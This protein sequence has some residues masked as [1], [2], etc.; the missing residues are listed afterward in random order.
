[1]NSAATRFDA[2]RNG[3]LILFPGEA[4]I[5]LVVAV[6]GQRATLLFSLA[7]VATAKFSGA[8]VGAVLVRAT[9]GRLLIGVDGD[10]FE[11]ARKSIEPFLVFGGVDMLQGARNLPLLVLP[12]VL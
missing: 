11:D 5:E 6:A 2:A 8:L 10:I 3:S 1:M 12:A 7:L 4:I 9:E